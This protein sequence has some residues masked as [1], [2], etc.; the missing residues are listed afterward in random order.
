MR[1]VSIW[2]PTV[3]DRPTISK[4]HPLLPPDEAVLIARYLQGG[5]PVLRTTEKERDYFAKNDELRVGMSS[6]TDGLYIWDDSLLYYVRTYSLS[7]G[8]EFI[9]HCR[10]IDFETRLPSKDELEMALENLLR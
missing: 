5:T 4:N 2:D 1:F 8:E 3:T 7:P 10:L 9:D 6:Y